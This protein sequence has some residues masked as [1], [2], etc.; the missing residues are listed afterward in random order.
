MRAVRVRPYKQGCLDS[1]CGVY[2]V[3]NAVRLSTQKECLM[4]QRDF[5]DIFKAIIA[6]LDEQAILSCAIKDGLGIYCLYRLLRIANQ[7]LTDHKGWSLTFRR[8]WAR[9]AATPELPVV[10]QAI[11]MHL[12]APR[13]STIVWIGGSLDHWSVPRSIEGESMILFDSA[14]YRDVRITIGDTSASPQSVD[15]VIPRG[16]FFISSYPCT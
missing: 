13:N 14:G 4:R 12:S 9:Q 3:I 8:P 11:K 2:C 6:D 16:T 5:Q 10:Y 7:W 15:D 1:L